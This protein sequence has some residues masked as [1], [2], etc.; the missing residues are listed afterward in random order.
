MID[1]AQPK[2]LAPALRRRINKWAHGQ[3]QRHEAAQKAAF[4]AK[5]EQAI[6]AGATFDELAALVDVIEA[7]L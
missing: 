2:P 6:A 4:T 5:I 1:M 3:G 7:S